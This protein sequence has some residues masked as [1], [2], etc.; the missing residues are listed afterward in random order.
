MG[1]RVPSAFEAVEMGG[2]IPRDYANG[3][4]A[5]D[6]NTQNA[7]QSSPDKNHSTFVKI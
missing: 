3:R 7:L 2:N 4:E 6:E 5:K 1:L